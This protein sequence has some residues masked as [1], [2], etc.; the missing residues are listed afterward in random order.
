MRWRHLPGRCCIAP[1]SS[2]SKEPVRNPARHVS[3]RECTVSPVYMW[4]CNAQILQAQSAQ[5]MF[6]VWRHQEACRTTI[7]LVLCSHMRN[8]PGSI[9]RT[10][11]SA[12]WTS[13]MLW[14]TPRMDSRADSCSY[15]VLDSEI[16]SVVLILTELQQCGES[17]EDAAIALLS[18]GCFLSCL[19]LYHI[20]M[21][22]KRDVSCSYIL[23]C[24]AIPG[25]FTH[26]HT[27]TED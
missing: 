24:S 12:L 26:N 18:A 16:H 3:L 4:H 10:P 17:D 2:P 13:G 27:F 14:M 1:E 15:M 20:Q 8:R 19:E 22:T 11:F 25:L 9:L 23:I 7:T 6:L 5:S 21:R